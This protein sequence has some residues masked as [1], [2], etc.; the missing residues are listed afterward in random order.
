MAGPKRVEWT[1]EA[2]NDLE[3]IHDSLVKAWS[4]STAEGF[5]N[6][7][8][9][10]EDLVIQYPFGFRASPVRPELRLG[11]IHRR[12]IAVYRVEPRR[13]LMIALLDTRADNKRFI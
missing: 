1:F 8:D 3:N 13:I 11:L 5:L 12:V 10:F 7:V 2:L 4:T 9:E 6:L